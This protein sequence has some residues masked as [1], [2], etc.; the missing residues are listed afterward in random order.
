[1]AEPHKRPHRH[2]KYKIRYRVKNWHEY[3]QSLRDRGDITLWISPD[4][5]NAWTPPMTGTRGAQPVYSAVAIA[6]ALTLR[7]LFRLPLR[8]TEGLLGSVL[9]LMDLT[10][11]CP[12]PTTLSRRHP[13]VAVRQH[14]DWA[15][16]GAISLIVDSSGLQVC[17]PG[18][19][20]SQKHGEKKH[21]RWKKRHIGVDAQGQIVASTMTESHAQDPSHVPA[22]LAQVDQPIDHFIG[23][24]MY[25]QEPV[26]AAVGDHSPGARVIIPPRTRMRGGTPQGRPHQPNAISILW[27]L[28]AR[29]GVHGNGRRV[30]TRRVTR[31]RPFSASSRSSAADYGQSGMRPRNG[32]PRWL[33]SCS[34]GCGSWGVLSPF[35]SAESRV[36]GTMA[37][38]GRFVQQ[39]R[40]DAVLDAPVAPDVAPERR[41]GAAGAPRT[42]RTLGS[43]AVRASA[44]S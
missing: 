27:R 4:T 24:G 36:Q 15:P 5:I 32:K 38:S 37:A 1:M 41:R 21:K 26:S 16:E 12:D 40:V 19:W 22:L 11:P 18:E 42:G 14:G 25:D 30:T 39:R 13:T 2:P 23:D 33:A 7:L 34:I 31:R 28:N 6:T 17:G 43:P 44:R 29:G 8:Q 35:P 20:Q 10:L 3:D 9:P